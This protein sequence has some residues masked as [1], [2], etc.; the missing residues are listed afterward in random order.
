MWVLCLA[1]PGQ[2]G[3][4][5]AAHKPVCLSWG[6][7]PPSNYFPCLLWQTSIHRSP[8]P[9]QERLVGHNVTQAGVEPPEYV[10]K[11]QTGI[12]TVHIWSPVSG[13]LYPAHLIW[14]AGDGTSGL[15]QGPGWQNLPAFTGPFCSPLTCPTHTH[16]AW[17]T[18][19]CPPW[20]SKQGKC[21]T[22]PAGG[23]V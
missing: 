21:S 17:V 4:G 19:R 5:E 16:P 23:H 1:R 14:Q 8:S 10:G 11:V 13:G 18:K 9:F 15:S 2:A 22:G 20:D 12:A 7:G 3:G 6:P